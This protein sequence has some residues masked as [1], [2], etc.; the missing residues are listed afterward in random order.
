MVPMLPTCSSAEVPE[1]F[2]VIILPRLREGGKQV[3]NQL[4]CACHYSGGMPP[5]PLEGHDLHNVSFAYICLL[6]Q[7]S[8]PCQV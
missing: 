8:V 7:K 6:F 2:P 5:D 1:Q 3:V 4:A